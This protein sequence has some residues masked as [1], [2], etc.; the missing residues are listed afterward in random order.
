MR[1]LYASF[2]GQQKSLAYCIWFYLAA[3]PLLFGSLTSYSQSTTNYTLG[4]VNLGQLPNY[5][6]VFTDARNDANWQGATK[7][8]VGDVA[9]DG[10]QADERT[11]GGVPY[12]GT[13]YT[14]DITLSAW[15][16]IVAQNTAPNVTTTQ[17]FSVGSQTTLIN[18]LTT[19][20]ENVFT[21][22]NA[23]PVTPGYAGV[24][25]LSLNGLN[26]QNGIAQTFVINITSGLQVSSQINITGD[27]SDIFIFRWDS[28][29]NFSNGY[30]G[31]VKFQSGGAF[32]PLGGLKPTNFI[33]VAGELSSSG[34]GSNPTAP[35]P[36]G[37]RLN[38][39]QGAL[40]QGGADF[41]GGG[42]FTGYWFTTGDPTLTDFGQP[43]GAQTSLSN[44][45]FVG[46]WYSKNTQFSMTSGTSGVYVSPPIV[47]ALTATA[48]PG[49]CNPTT[50]QYTISGTIS[51]TNNAT[52]GTAT[53]TDGAK[54]TTVSIAANATST[55][56][57]LTG[58]TSGAGSHTVTVSLPSCGTTTAVYSA[59]ASCFTNTTC[60]PLGLGA[61]SQFGIL[62]LNNGSIIINSSSSLKG[63]VG[64]SA[65]VTSTTN[66]KVDVFT[67]TVYVSSQVASF[68]YTPATFAPSGGIIGS[69]TPSATADALLNQANID[70]L[71]AS[72]SYAALPVNVNLGVLGD[73]DNRT[74]N[75][76]GPTTVVQ[77]SSLN[78]NSDVITLVGQAGQNDLFIINVLGS[79]EFSQ[80]IV[81]LTNV[82]P[83][84][85]LWNFPN[86][87]T[88]IDLNKSASIFQ[89]TILAPT[90]LVTYHNPATFNGAIIA[91]DIYVHSDFNLDYN[92][93]P[94]CPVC[95][96][97]ATAVPGNCNTA[98]NQ[99]AVSG[100]ISLTSNAAGGT[101][102]I[103]DGARSITVTVTPSATSVPYSLTGLTSGTGSH[104]VTVTL[105]G[106]G[107]AVATYSA[108][109]SCTV[110]A[111][112]TV[113]SATV[114]A[115]QTAT[116]TA[117]GCVGTVTWSTGTSPSSGTLV[118][119]A[120]SAGTTTQTILSYTATCTPTTGA[121]A[122][123]VATV[124]VNPVP[125]ATLSSA[126]ICAGQTAT[127][128]ATGGTSYTLLN[129]NTVNTTGTF[130]VTPASTTSYTVVV[131]N[132]SGCTATATGTVTVN[133]LPT[134][135]LSSTAICAG[136]T[137]TLTA[138][139]GTSYTLLNTNTV[140]T[141]GIFTVTPGSTTS[142]TVIAGN[143]SGCTAT[144]TGT[145][146]VNPAPTPTLS[147]VAI[148]AG[149]TATLTATGGTSYTLSPGNIINT[150]GTFT[151]T[152]ASTTTYT[153]VTSNAS[154]CTA[155]ATGTVT[156]SPAPTPTLS[157]VAI[158]AGATAT[159]TATGGTS[160]TLSPGNLVNTTGTFTVT[161]AST[162]TY[163]VVASNAS[164][165]TATATG[166]VTV[167]PA[168][169]PT[170]SSMALPN[171]WTGFG[172][173]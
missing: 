106:C 164:S 90:S 72:S 102:T 113:T 69:P 19:D 67:G 92:T 139:G 173:I 64:Y 124:T 52:G 85:V 120:T 5:H 33:H 62:G 151:V 116:L 34:G 76:V 11:S 66:Q 126:T 61:A 89:G 79:F 22:V 68:D 6:L 63:N 152:P 21:Q 28:D 114:C 110:P 91:K 135:T 161:P 16:G 47:C 159:L 95:S 40:V 74:V 133:P 149:A 84:R 27:A 44:G 117:S 134:P 83:A 23:L 30:T 51:L 166:T 162:T 24:S 172:S 59:P 82:S 131:S 1:L 73:N 108:P 3:V 167:N 147:S 13:I 81:Q 155:T 98:T 37:P 38:N 141:T 125:T 112:I 97:T 65:G 136:A 60:D 75:R 50:N 145:V 121:A 111:V 144:A 39:G 104:T 9:V 48:T 146:T 4:G 88:Q 153:V 165:C 12:A 169:T 26:T 54:S 143:A 100:T 154:S 150:T 87:N 15:S 105:A 127:L 32:I 56:Y 137:A 78:Y 17:A 80:S 2:Y 49:Q 129:T 46:G 163:T 160:Y 107:S 101:A 156:V 130:T 45:I 119:V 148:C 43:Y 158:C 29:A 41:N 99:Y 8:F 10:L 18:N 58:L 53:I 71:A 42:F 96:L 94:V 86:A 128:T 142:Y 31:Q 140:N 138:T 103:T 157:S 118:T 109:A 93:P 170:L 168:P 7:G 14:N 57:S 115:G 122:T 171:S 55:A 25:T 20:L 77:I 35:Y 132:A 70:A 36:Q 123:A